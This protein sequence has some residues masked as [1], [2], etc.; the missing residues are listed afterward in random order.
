MR[1]FEEHLQILREVF[2]RLRS[3]IETKSQ[4]MPVL[5]GSFE[6]PWSHRGLR[7]DPE[8][9]RADW[10]KSRVKQIRQFLWYRRIIQDFA[11]TAT[12]LTALT[13]KN[14]R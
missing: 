6:K 10:L 9:I 7:T 11:T 3:E 2:G 4:Q 12:P 5:S 1:S 13:K 14:I 8:K